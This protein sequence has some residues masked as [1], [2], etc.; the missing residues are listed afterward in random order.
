MNPWRCLGA[1]IAL[2]C[3]VSLGVTN[4]TVEALAG[5][6]ELIGPGGSGCFGDQ[7]VPLSTGNFVVTD[8]CWSNDK[9]AAY[10]YDGSNRT[11]IAALTGSMSG[12]KV[13]ADITVLANGNYVVS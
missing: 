8:P 2:A 11:V 1:S 13:G 9:G 7:V 10:L 5:H 4:P 6:A 12:D 3:A